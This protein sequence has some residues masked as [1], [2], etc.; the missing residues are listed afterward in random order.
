M[1]P[2]AMQAAKRGSS[3]AQRGTAR[4]VVAAEA[5]CDDADLPAVDVTSLFKEID[6]SAAGFFIIVAQDKS[7]ETDRLA[8][9]GAV[10]DQDRDAA[11]DQVRHAGEV[12]DLLGDVEAVEEYDARRAR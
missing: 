12:L 4:R 1:A 8:G 9:A 2:Q 7:A 3:A 10:H 6:A 11:L 5:D